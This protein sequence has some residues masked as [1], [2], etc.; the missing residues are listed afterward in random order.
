MVSAL[1]RLKP[2]IMIHSESCLCVPATTDIF[3]TPPTQTSVSI[4]RK[5][6]FHPIANITDLGPLEFSI[7]GCE[8]DY[9]DLNDHCLELRLKVVKND[10]KDIAAADKVGPVNFLLH[11]LFS[12]ID[13]HLNGT[14]ITTPSNAYPYKAYI[15]KQLNYGSETKK[16]LFGCELY[17]KDTAGKMDIHDPSAATGNAGL[18]ARAKYFETS[19]TVVLRGSLHFAFLNQARLLLNQVGLRIKLTPH[20]SAFTLMSAADNYKITMVSA[21]FEMT[22]VTL[23]P[24]VVISHNRMLAKQNAKYSFRRAE[25]KTFS[26]ATGNMQAVKESLFM[27]QIPRRLIFGLVDSEAF[28]GVS[29]K[30][31]F[32]FKHYNL[33]FLCVTVNS[34]RYPAR[35]FTPNFAKDDFVEAYE[36]L[37][38]GMGVKS[39]S[40]KSMDIKR[41]EYPGGYT[42]YVLALCPSN[43]ESP[44]LDLYEKGPIRLE[45]KFGAFLPHPVTAIVYAEYE[46]MLEIDKD[47]NIILQQ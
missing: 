28:A 16:T 3:F 18:K 8:D 44:S 20:T 11:A 39:D 46:T 30:N 23:N 33:N 37:F 38:V 14:L 2:F 34:D 26:I 21:R 9:W 40:S 36:S 35:P 4:R 25:I 19:K 31:P 47:R 32:N 29:T 27:G 7:P 42:L 10:G 41:D 45:V 12:Q 15:E 24:E 6:D 43:P 5:V 1:F 13:I 17:H 22:K